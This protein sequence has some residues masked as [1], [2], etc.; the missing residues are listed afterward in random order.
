[1]KR[2]PL[3]FIVPVLL[4]INTIILSQTEQDISIAHLKSNMEFLADD[5]LEGRNAASKGEK[6]AALFIAKELQKYGVQPF[7]D[8]GTYFQNFDLSVTGFIAGSGVSLVSSDEE[9][10]FEN[11]EDIV[12]YRRGGLPDT[13]ISGSTVDIV[14]AGYGLKSEESE[15]ISYRF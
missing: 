5:L 4:L 2:S 1:M 10:Y 12:F 3:I 8:S 11:G 15:S 9:K 14:F 6:I 13:S 7:G